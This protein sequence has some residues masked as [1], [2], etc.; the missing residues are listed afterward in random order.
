MLLILI[1]HSGLLYLGV[2]VHE[3]KNKKR[4]QCYSII[5]NRTEEETE[6]Q[7]NTDLDGYFLGQTRVVKIVANNCLTCYFT[8]E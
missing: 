5:D 4:N 8:I 7:P 1:P 6:E 3:R 2:L